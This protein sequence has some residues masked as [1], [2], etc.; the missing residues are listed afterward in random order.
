MVPPPVLLWA[1]LGRLAVP[2]AADTVARMDEGLLRADIGVN[3]VWRAT[4]EGQRLRRV[5]H[6]ADGRLQEWVARASD[7]R[8]EYRHEA[9]RRRLS[10]S[11]TSVER[12]EGFDAS[13]WT[14]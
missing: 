13:I 4:F 12:V 11:I 2:A 9:S 10:L 7:T 14:R 3:P 8:V 1:S 6:I 5:E